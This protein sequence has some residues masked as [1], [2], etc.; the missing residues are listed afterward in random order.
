[1]KLFGLKSKGNRRNCTI[2]ISYKSKNH[3]V[4]RYISEALQSIGCSVWH[5]EYKI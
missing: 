3:A 4:A 1:M 2:F 5:A